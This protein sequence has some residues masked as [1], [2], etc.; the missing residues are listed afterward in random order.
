MKAVNNALMSYI[1]LC[2]VYVK[3]KQT[4]QSCSPLKI[5]QSINV[6]WHTCDRNDKQLFQRKQE[7]PWPF[8]KARNALIEKNRDM[9]N[10]Y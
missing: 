4:N 3:F 10:F 1:K 2:Y 7:Q 6:E 9:A 8:D 5:S